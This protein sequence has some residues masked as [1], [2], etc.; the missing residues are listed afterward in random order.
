MNTT[1][2]TTTNNNY[3]NDNNNNDNNIWRRNKSNVCIN[4][5]NCI[6]Q[7]DWIED[8]LHTVINWVYS[9]HV[10]LISLFYKI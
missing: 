9:L 5:D 8:T 6:I 10:H 2:A 3:N 7:F 4:H 1:T